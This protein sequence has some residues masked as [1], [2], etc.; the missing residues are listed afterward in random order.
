M[1]LNSVKKLRKLLVIE[2]GQN[3]IQAIARQVSSQPPQQ[4]ALGLAGIGSN[5]PPANC[6]KAEI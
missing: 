6:K 1:I 5:R 4:V 2:T 3:A